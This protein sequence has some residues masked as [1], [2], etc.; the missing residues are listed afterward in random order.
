M[1]TAHN[2]HISPIQSTNYRR[3]IMITLVRDIIPVLDGK[4]AKWRK[5]FSIFFVHGRLRDSTHQTIECIFLP[6]SLAIILL[7]L[8][9]ISNWI[10]RCRVFPLTQT[11]VQTHSK[12]SIQWIFLLTLFVLWCGIFV[13]ALQIS[14]EKQLLFIL[15]SLLVVFYVES[16]RW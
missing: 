3:I 16:F 6:H 7:L 10:R 11:R 15:L 4:A 1:H 8:L 14:W 13:S 12:P 9:H 2:H 5:K